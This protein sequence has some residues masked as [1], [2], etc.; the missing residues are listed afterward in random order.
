M[1]E[2]YFHVR[3]L[4]VMAVF[5][6]VGG[7]FILTTPL[8]QAVVPVNLP[9]FGGLLFVPLATIFMFVAIGVVEKPGTATITGTILGVVTFLFPGGPGVLSLPVW[10]L[11][12]I[13]IDIYLLIIRRGVNDSPL[14]AGSAAFIPH[15][16]TTWWVLWIGYGIFFGRIIPIW[17]FMAV[18]IGLQGIVSVIG[19]IGGHYVLRRVR[20]LAV[21]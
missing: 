16:T 6:A 12:G 2:E 3:D 20:R 11:K 5:G 21:Y 13:V 14:I 15:L 4:V 17:I 10:I 19:G 18:F 9:G 1:S 7:S 8:V